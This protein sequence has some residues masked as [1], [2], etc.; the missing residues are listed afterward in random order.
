M[1]IEDLKTF[2]KA[3]V[4]GYKQWGAD[5][6]Q[7]WKDDGLFRSSVPIVVTSRFGQNTRIAVEG[8]EASEAR[9]WDTERDFTKVAYLTFAL[10]T[11]IE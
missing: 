6:P 10:A 5:A 2:D 11:S 3:I 7:K 4:D 9:N 1:N 8:N